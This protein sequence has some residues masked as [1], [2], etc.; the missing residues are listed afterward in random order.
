M[1]ETTTMRRIIIL[2]L[3][4]LIPGCQSAYINGVPNERSPYFQVPVDSK[5]I[6]QRAITIEPTL[7]SAYFQ[8]GRMIPWHQVNE[9]GAYCA[10]ILERK[11]DVEQTVKPGK[12]MVQK[13]SNEN[14]FTIAK[15]GNRN[16]IPIAFKS[17]VADMRDSNG[18]TYEVLATVMELRSDT[19][20]EVRRLTC[21]DW[22][23]PQGMPFLTVE[24]IRQS[25][26]DFFSLKLAL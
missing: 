1:E 5:L 3:F 13:V 4:I 8:R 24:T 21:A 2:F 6:L 26:G 18:E 25:L 15:A 9:Y 7:K 23:I 12:F 11:R 19:Q 14:L 20:P 22:G 17:R 16:L 10:L